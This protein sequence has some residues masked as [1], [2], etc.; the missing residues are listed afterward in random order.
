[1]SLQLSIIIP[2]YNEEENIGK[3]VSY[4]QKKNLHNSAEI[5]LCD[6]QST[7]KTVEKAKQAGAK[8]IISPVK[9]RAA[10]MNYAATFA[11]SDIL[12]F[13]H[14]DCFP[15]PAFIEHIANAVRDGYQLGRYRTKFDS[16]NILLKI[17][18]W[19]TRFDWLICYGGDQTLFITKELFIKTGGFKK[20]MLIME[21]Y[22]LVMRGRQFASYKIF[23]ERTLVSAR[24]YEKN[25]WIKVQLANI[26]I[27]KMFKSGSSQ[28]EM[29]EQYKALL[30]NR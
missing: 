2:T 9:G 22:D 21:E 17:N 26:R 3:L 16:E 29:V 27:I 5:I 14:S 6:G 23:K 11:N 30:N 13:V 24:K 18:A 1:M 8:I 15:P 20:D 19:F 4:L 25:S 12:Y 7:D 28:N 10:Q